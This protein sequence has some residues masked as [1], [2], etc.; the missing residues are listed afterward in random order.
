[1]R[2]IDG[3]VPVPESYEEY[4]LLTEAQKMRIRENEQDKVMATKFK[5]VQDSVTRWFS[6]DCA[7]L[8]KT[9]AHANV[10]ISQIETPRMEFDKAMLRSGDR[11]LAAWCRAAVSELAAATPDGATV[12]PPVLH[13]ATE[14]FIVTAWLEMYVM[15]SNTPLKQ[16]AVETITP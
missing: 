4:L 5:E 12:T 16:E 8:G 7:V 3:S 15:V 6:S 10:T 11:D 14:A 2:T 1:M 9:I 13:V